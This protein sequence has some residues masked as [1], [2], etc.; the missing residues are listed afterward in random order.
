MRVAR[1]VLGIA[2]GLLSVFI[3]GYAV[4]T[5]NNL[6]GDEMF[7]FAYLAFFSG[8]AAGLFIGLPEWR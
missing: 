3:V 1:T 7:G 5:H 6:S 4:I 8:V 2:F